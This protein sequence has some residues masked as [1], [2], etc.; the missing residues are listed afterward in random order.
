[1][2]PNRFRGLEI[3]EDR[4]LLSGVAAV[5]PVDGLDPLGSLVCASQ[6]RVGVVTGSTDQADFPWCAEAGA[7]AAVSVLENT[8]AATTAADDAPVLTSPSPIEWWTDPALQNRE[9]FT[10]NLSPHYWCKDESEQFL[11]VTTSSGTAGGSAYL[12]SIPSLIAAHAD[13]APAPVASVATA[14]ELGVSFLRG[15]AVSD[16]L[17]RVLTGTASA[18]PVYASL[19]TN[20]TQ[21]TSSTVAKITNDQNVVHDSM[22]FSHD[23]TQLFSNNYAANRNRVYTWNVGDLTSDGVGLTQ[24]TTFDSSVSRIRSLSSYYIGGKDLVYFGDGTGG[25]EVA[26]YDPAAGSETVLVTGLTGGD[27]IY[28]KVSGVGTG[29]MY[30]YVGA[31]VAGSPTIATISV[32][33][34]A[35]DGKSLTSTAP[36]ASFTGAALMTDILGVAPNYNRAFEVTNDGQ[37]GFFGTHA[38]GNVYTVSADVPAANTTPEG[39]AYT[40]DA[41][42]TD[43]GAPPQTLTFSLVDAPSG[44]A[45]DPASGVFTWTPSEEQGPGDYTFRVRVSDGAATDDEWV[46]LRVTEVNVAPVLTGVPATASIA[47]LTAYT[48]DANATDSD[49]P[50]QTLTFSLLSAPTGVAIDPA[51]GVFTWTP[52]EEQGPGDYPFTV[53]VS[54]GTTNTDQSVTLTVTVGSLDVDGN[55]AADALTDG[56]LILRYLFDSAGAWNYS[57]ALGGNATRTTR[58]TIKN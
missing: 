1:L 45:I 43:A 24:A 15:G 51:S 22:A 34:L 52:S 16:D 19:P 57:D 47:E 21:W 10:G 37:F 54:D 55:G 50:A 48:F 38:A 56:I 44:A 8:T 58:P 26:V 17:G 18:S 25:D 6:E 20:G 5:Q 28:V 11:F 36:V 30:L 9:A 41:D 7:G 31:E 33:A 53:R 40:F 12:Y 49:V 35:A 2:W 32:Y 3:L 4:Y 39:A 13:N 46:T 27:I 29:Q 14:A 42:A 23:S